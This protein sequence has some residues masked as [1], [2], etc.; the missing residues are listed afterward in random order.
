MDRART[1]VSSCRSSTSGSTQRSR[2]PKRNG[3]K[4]PIGVR[5]ERGS[6]SRMF[7]SYRSASPLLAAFFEHEAFHCE[8]TR[9]GGSRGRQRVD[10]TTA[11]ARKAEWKWPGDNSGLKAPKARRGVE[12]GRGCRIADRKVGARATHPLLKRRRPGPGKVMLLHGSRMEAVLA[13]LAE[14]AE[15]RAPQESAG[16]Y[17][18]RFATGASE[19][20]SRD[21][22]GQEVFLAKGTNKPPRISR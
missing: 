14:S 7:Q 18:A 17:R 4:E 13:S 11:S 21:C 3:S 2:D 9:G 12:P 19:A 8:A 6:G 1:L 10:E 16:W 20:R 15:K 5:G 22:V